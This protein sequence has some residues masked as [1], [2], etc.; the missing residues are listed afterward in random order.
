M[1]FNSKKPIEIKSNKVE[2]GPPRLTI[3]EIARIIGARATQIAFGAP[4]LVPLSN[5]DISRMNEV[6]IAKLELRLGLL[7]ITVQRWLPDGRYQNIP[8][9]WLKYEEN[10]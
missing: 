6:D 3:Y 7:P 10:I 9:Q 5:V 4:I 1:S 8:I 2:I